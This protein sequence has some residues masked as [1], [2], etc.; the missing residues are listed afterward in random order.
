MLAPLL[1]V[2]PALR[3]TQGHARAGQPP[4]HILQ[5]GCDAVLSSQ[6]ASTVRLMELLW[7]NGTGRGSVS[8]LIVRGWIGCY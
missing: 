1:A 8:A 3:H 4:A 2:R 6:A 7:G 5:L